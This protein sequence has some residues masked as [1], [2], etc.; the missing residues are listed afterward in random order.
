MIITSGNVFYFIHVYT[1]LGVTAYILGN[2]QIIFG[3]KYKLT[4]YM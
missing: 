3:T 4:D 2:V 1:Y